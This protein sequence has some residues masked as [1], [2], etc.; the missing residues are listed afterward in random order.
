MVDQNEKD[1]GNAQS[2]L[3]VKPGETVLGA[4]GRMTGEKPKILLRDDDSEHGA[5]S[6]YIDPKGKDSKLFPQGRGNYQ[7]LGEIARG[8]MGVVLKGHDTDLG[9]DVA[10]KVLDQRLLGNPAVLQRFVEEAQI[11]GQLQHPGVVPVYELG[12]MAD[13]RPYFS[14]KLV[15]GRT[16]AALL[17]QR[18]S[19]EDDRRRF[20]SIFESVCQT[21]AYAHSKGVIHRDLK[22]ANI[23][24][25]A[26]GEV[27]V[28]DWGLAKVLQ[29]GGVADEMMA[30]QTQMTVI[31]T[32]RS[33]PGSDGSDSVVGSVMGTPA[34]MSP[35]QAMGEIERVDE[36]ADVFA[37]GAILCE[38]ISGK[39]PYVSGEKERTVVLAAGAKL[40]PARGRVEACAADP[41]LKEITLEC[42]APAPTVRPQNAQELSERM[43]AYLA[44]QEE[45]AHQAEIAAT[46]ARE[47]RRRMRLAMVLAATV[48][49]AGAAIAFV[50]RNA[51]MARLDRI[52]T[53]R[54]SID[55]AQAQMI[56]LHESGQFAEALEVARSTVSLVESNDAADATTTA[57]AE[58]M[59]TLANQRV[60]EDEARR[61]LERRNAELLSRCDVLR[62]KQIEALFGFS[63]LTLNAELDAAYAEAFR[64]YGIDLEDEDLPATMRRLRDSGIAVE[65]AL[66][67]DDWATVRRSERGWE[68]YE[69]ESVT[70]LAFDLD[71]D[72]LRTRMREALLANDG[73][74]LVAIA[75]T[76][77][78]GA[79]PASSLW[80]LSQGLAA[81]RVPSRT[82]SRYDDE[83]FEVVRT[84][85]R[86]HPSDF[87]LN[88]RMGHL[89]ADRDRDEAALRH[90]TVASALR[91][92]NG[93]VFALLGDAY[94][95]LQDDAAA[96]KA[97]DQCLRLRPDLHRVHRFVGWRAF[98]SGNLER[99]VEAYDQVDALTP[100][101]PQWEF[102]GALARSF[103]GLGPM[104][105]VADLAVG[106]GSFERGFACWGLNYHPDPAQR[107]PER[108]HG[109]AQ[110]IL[111]NGEWRLGA[112]LLNAGA[113]LQL[114]RAEEALE[115]LEDGRG[116]QEWAL[117]AMR[118]EYHLM[119]AWT[120]L[121]LGDV[122]QARRS[123]GKAR[124]LYRPLLYDGWE[125]WRGSVKER[126]FHDVQA[127]LGD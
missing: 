51:E 60:A 6:P 47:Q 49:V 120:H 96:W 34:Y 24:V 124:W 42:L 8:G 117:R 11:G 101:D 37:L 115:I 41:E 75:R 97:Y 106:R 94:G 113:L 92:R 98:L 72:P 91:P 25:G 19:P 114:G 76:E 85:V 13:D 74:A 89:Y 28:V 67:L 105:D 80:V 2:G 55:E 18:K 33:G 27:Q 14:M 79:M 109:L 62:M 66:A 84:G 31:E 100:G 90:L 48:I 26:F 78:L 1:E 95:S 57:R 108:A 46:E 82:L 118:A 23:M 10:V 127:R 59:L 116:G 45:K 125:P 52:A 7:I 77:D 53:L 99:A 111:A 30:R 12:L 9:R 58:R 110:E 35:E 36:R 103:A 88:F 21:V 86:A 107:D 83:I 119:L 17:A 104:A 112:Y 39:P 56:G 4:V 29:G 126:I 50:L 123:L 43:H 102:E 122:E 93:A 65:A 87:L 70:A 121:E 15:K 3:D 54:S 81:F 64:E 22:P 68:S 69:V 16:L 20:L 32:V 44:A 5:A 61:D 63:A 71:P 40:E 73:E 38:I